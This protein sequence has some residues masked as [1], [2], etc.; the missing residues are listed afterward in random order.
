MFWPVF[1]VL[2]WVLVRHVTRRYSS[3]A[4]AALLATAVF[5]Q[6][7]DTSAG[8]RPVR[9]ELSITGDT[10][11]SPLKSPFWTRV[12]EKYD[13]IRLL[14]PKNKAPNYATFAYFAAMHGLVTDA[15]YLAR[16]DLAKLARAKREAESAI[17][18]GK[19][20][21]RTLYVLNEDS[22]ESDARARLRPGIDLLKRI[23][24][25]LVLAPG[26]TEPPSPAA[27]L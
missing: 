18:H 21:S 23:D 25:V 24:G 10:W 5:L 16:I 13:V 17:K 27:D 2:L 6:A 19:F 1:Y 12:P 8:W 15:V 3:R 11:P 4:A 14:P 26:W 7:V 9:R 22:L 20:A